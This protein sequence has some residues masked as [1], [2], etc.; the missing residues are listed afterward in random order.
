[1]NEFFPA[2][3]TA[4][5]RPR[6]RLV[7]AS[8]PA[9]GA[10]LPMRPGAVA[11]QAA[12]S[13]AQAAA[14]GE[15]ACRAAW[16]HLRFLGV[17]GVLAMARNRAPAQVDGGLPAPG[18]IAAEVGHALAHG[19]RPGSARAILL[20]AVLADARFDGA[21]AARALADAAV[22]LAAPGPERDV[23]TRLHAA[24]VLARR[25]PFAQCLQA[26]GA[27][28]QT[29]DVLRWS[30]L[31][32]GAGVAL[33]EIL[34][35]LQSA[36]DSE[37]GA[38]R[39]AVLR[40]L[41]LPQPPHLALAPAPGTSFATWTQRLQLAWFSGDCAG[42]C[43]AALAAAPLA[44]PLDAPADV[45]VFHLFGALA[46]A[47]DAAPAC[48]HALQWHR[49]E[50]AG[51]AARVDANAGAMAALADAVAAASEGDVAAALRGYE[52]AAGKA[53]GHGQT[54]V[55]ALAWEL[56]AVL[57]R[58]SGLIAAM[59]AYRRRALMAWHAC[60][61]HGRIAR[62][63]QQWHQAEDAP[64]PAPGW[65]CGDQQHQQDHQDEVRRLARVGTVGE[66][67]VTIAHEVNQPL[68]AILLQAAAAR[69]WLRRPR[70]D[71]DRALEAIEQIAVSGRRAGDIV[72]SVQG[73]ARRHSTGLTVFPVDA[74]L[75]EA[76]RLLGGALRKHD[77]RAHLALE[78]PDCQIHANRAQ[79]QQVVINLLMNAIDALVPV[80]G[81]AREIVLASRR[82][83]AG[84]IEISVA[85]NGPGVA[86]FDRDHIFDALFST[87][88]HG[89]GV[90]LSLSRAIAEAH[91]GH[92]SYQPRLP[93]GALF[94]LVLAAEQVDPDA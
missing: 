6:R 84:T 29:Q 15:M 50:L 76:L 87:K 5:G 25:A 70:P 90:G 20:L 11:A 22:A 34:Q 72:R 13:Q 9:G 18:A 57:C 31:R 46:L 28:L 75:E 17:A 33:P 89:T 43:R 23:V 52:A 7:Q 32:L 10:R 64:V 14:R 61:A 92:I 56:A 65:P 45:L 40:A 69:R 86:P 24:L 88:P 21:G 82:I 44:G 94:A 73:L 49:I 48:R 42:A 91:G 62:L 67:G 71:L 26:F 37:E 8:R 53:A 2:F 19:L 83:D 36:Q 81:R 59:P 74:A 38:A 60:G 54:W 39:V 30:A 55:T 12:V 68:A 58:Q 3:T 93:H 16:Q 4:D 80:A 63:C 77:V 1:M 27:Q 47:W 79:V 85:D 66:L 35:G 51:A 41:V 78:L